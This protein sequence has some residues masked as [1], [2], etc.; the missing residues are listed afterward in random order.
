MD[1]CHRNKNRCKMKTAPIPV[2][3]PCKQPLSGGERE[4]SHE[5]GEGEKERD[6][7]RERR[8]EREREKTR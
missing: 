3:L 4:E 1:G 5:G 2:H 6:E 8:T 7:E